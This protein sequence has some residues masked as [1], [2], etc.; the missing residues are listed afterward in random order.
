MTSSVD[1]QDLHNEYPWLLRVPRRHADYLQPAYYEELLHEY[2]FGSQTDLELLTSF[3]ARLENPDDRRVLELGCGSG[4]ATEVLLRVLGAATT[5]DLVDLSPQMIAHC[6]QKFTGNPGVAVYESDSLDFVSNVLAS[7]DVVVSLWNLSHSVHQHMLREGRVRATSRVHEAIQ[8]LVTHRL[9]R[10]GSVFLIHYDIQS[11]EQRLINPWRKF[12]WEAAG[13]DYDVSGQAPSKQLLDEVL[14]SAQQA[15]VIEFE[16]VHHA[17]DPIVYDSPA[18][19]LEVF[20]NFHMEGVFN[21]HP[22]V[23]EVIESFRAGIGSY[24]EDGTVKIAP[25]CFTYSIVGT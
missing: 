7:Y 10:G 17:G 23:G 16:C 15:G 20:M 24:T 3:L 11:P 4:R 22:R 25:G 12:I 8:Q 14:T 13:L 5:V 1:L 21:N 2:S 18:R 6:R 9:R 19:A